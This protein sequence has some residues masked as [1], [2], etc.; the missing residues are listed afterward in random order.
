MIILV[1][2]AAKAKKVYEANSIE[3]DYFDY[4]D[5][6][7][8]IVW[9]SSLRQLTLINKKELAYFGSFLLTS[10]EKILEIDS[11]SV[12]LIFNKDNNLKLNYLNIFTA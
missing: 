10:F 5:Y 1:G 7:L 4:F 2:L 8:I 9:L 6:L 12:I 3:K 11:W